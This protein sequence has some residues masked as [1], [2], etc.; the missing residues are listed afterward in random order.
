MDVNGHDHKVYNLVKFSM[1]Y[2]ITSSCENRVSKAVHYGDISV[3]S[4]G[5]GAL[6][7]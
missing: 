4:L 1:L 6:Y 5:L 3:R 7:K 2:S